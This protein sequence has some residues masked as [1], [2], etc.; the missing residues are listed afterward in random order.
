[1]RTL[2]LI[3]AFVFVL[4]CP[5]LVPS[6]GSGLPGPGTFSYN[7]S[8]VNMAAPRVLVAEAR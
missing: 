5:A 4:C 2:S 3:L 6:S 1:M 7:G 8:A